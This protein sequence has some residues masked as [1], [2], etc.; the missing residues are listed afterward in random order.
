MTRLASSILPHT[1]SVEKVSPVRVV[2]REVHTRLNS[3][4]HPTGREHE[5]ILLTNTHKSQIFHMMHIPAL[6]PSKS[7]DIWDGSWPQLIGLGA[8]TLDGNGQIDE[9]IGT[10]LVSHTLPKNRPPE[11]AKM[12]YLHSLAISPYH[13]GIGLAKFLF[14]EQ[15][16][17]WMEAYCASHGLH[18]GIL[19]TVDYFNNKAI[20]L[21]LSAA[22]E[23]WGSKG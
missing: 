15:G 6:Y 13:Q 10:L 2:I 16:I 20:K 18:A 19:L 9:L 23:Y 21:Y 14:T 1:V 22:F 7:E 11:M 5:S 4:Q 12:L 17:F 8:F 3:S